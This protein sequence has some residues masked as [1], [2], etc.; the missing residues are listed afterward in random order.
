M[1]RKFFDTSFAQSA[2]LKTQIPRV[3]KFIVSNQNTAL[4]EAELVALI[5]PIRT[6]LKTPMAEFFDRILATGSLYNFV[7]I[8]AVNQ[9]IDIPELVSTSSI[10]LDL[11]EIDTHGSLRSLRDFTDKVLVDT[12]ATLRQD[13]SYGNYYVNAVDTFQSLFVRGQM[14]AAY[15]DVPVWITPY[16]AEYILKTYSMIL[17]GIITRYYNLSLPEMMKVG[18]FCAYFF[19]QRLFDTLPGTTPDAFF[20]CTWLGGQNEL[21]EF[22]AQYGATEFNHDIELTELAEIL[23]KNINARMNSFNAN[24]LFTMCGSLGP[25]VLSSRIALEYPPYWLF[26]LLQALSGAK[27]PM[28]YQLNNQR[29]TQDG[30]TKFLNQL[31]S[32]N[33]LFSSTRR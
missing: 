23:S 31:M 30:R 5:Q 25:D 1:K 29:L 8:S 21:R 28:I 33:T 7:A 26:T 3:L 11:K 17:S 16:V 20:K 2:G 24:V 27:I 15:N 12:T 13:H 18:M 4:S 10:T 14:I 19:A 6:I 32:A 22:A 9:Q